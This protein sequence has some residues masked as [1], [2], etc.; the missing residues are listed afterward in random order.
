[1]A[2]NK[3]LLK[4]LDG[5]LTGFW[6]TDLA[7][8]CAHFFAG[9][10]DI[11]WIGFYLTDGERLR[12]GPFAGRVACTEIDFT[13]GVCGEAF[14]NDQLMKVD[15]VSTF[16]NHIVCDA[17]SKS[18]LVIPFHVNG[19]LCGVLDIDAP[20]KARFTDKEVALF[21]EAL[22]MLAARISYFPSFHESS[23]K[24]L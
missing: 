18:E 21:T 10:K 15:D 8:F 11:N 9:V 19:E 3:E 16:A 23:S 7:N 12:L 24:G 5:V 22:N 17:N 13:R 1:M 20:V 4:E 2:S 14:S 6:L